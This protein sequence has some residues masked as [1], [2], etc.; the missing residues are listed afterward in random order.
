[1]MHAQGQMALILGFLAC[2]ARRV[3]E[4]SMRHSSELLRKTCA[5]DASL[6]IEEYSAFTQQVRG[7]SQAAGM[8]A[9]RRSSW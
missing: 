4:Q 3:M 6:S 9:E 2:Y 1:M 5:R 8:A 7:G